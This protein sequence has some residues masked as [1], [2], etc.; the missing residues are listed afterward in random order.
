MDSNLKISVGL[1]PDKP[2]DPND[3]TRIN[4]DL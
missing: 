4:F 3:F 2:E 1:N